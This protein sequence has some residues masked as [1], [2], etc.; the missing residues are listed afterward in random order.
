MSSPCQKCP[1]KIRQVLIVE[2]DRLDQ[3]LDAEESLTECMLNVMD[4]ACAEN[5][6]I[7]GGIQFHRIT[8]EYAELV[9]DAGVAA[10]AREISDL[11][12]RFI[13]TQTGK[14]FRFG[15]PEWHKLFEQI[16]ALRAAAHPPQEEI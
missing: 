13:E 2:C 11:D 16:E 14:Q 7:K 4:D 12:Y 8:D 10:R 3:F 6:G 1:P 5:V 9:E 15:D